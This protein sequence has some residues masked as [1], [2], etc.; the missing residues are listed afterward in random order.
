MN[1]YLFKILQKLMAGPVGAKRPIWRK[2]VDALIL[3]QLPGMITCREFDSFLQ[4]YVDE[5]LS[6]NQLELF[7]I[8]MKLCP[9][10]NAHFETYMVS[11]KATRHVFGTTEE[12]VPDDVP[13][14]LITAIL[15][16]TRNAK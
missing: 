6:D 11:Y 10:C 14:D 9:M 4:D 5:E 7:D 1:S 15:D 13:E 16:T 12:T 8:H 3:H 2:F